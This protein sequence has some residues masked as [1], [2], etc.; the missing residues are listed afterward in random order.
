MTNKLIDYFSKPKIS[1]F[2]YLAAILYLFLSVEYNPENIVIYTI[3]FMLFMFL[4]D[5]LN[6]K[7]YKVEKNHEV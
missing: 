5:L 3:L 1:Y 6:N 7:K 2:E 4:F